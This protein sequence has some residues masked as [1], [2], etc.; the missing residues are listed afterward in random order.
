MSNELLSTQLSIAE[1]DQ[2]AFAFL[3][4]QY[5]KQLKKFAKALVRS[6]EISEEIVED[7]FVK[8]WCNR[9]T[10]PQIENLIVYMYVAV[11]NTS[12]NTLSK[13][14]HELIS[15][16]FDFLDIDVNDQSFNPY[17]LLITSEMMDR[18]QGAINS[19]PP[20]CKMIFKLVREDGLRYKEIAEILNISVNT[21]DV[22]M[23]IAIK[24]ICSALDV[25]KTHKKG[26]RNKVSGEY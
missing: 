19:L 3:Y 2:K 24:R 15:A 20:R 17:E 25:Q 21:I 7:V 26:V 14:S 1:G 12:L 22:Q 4:K 13:K 8:L 6:N 5:N 9:S 10:L 23:S 11:K 16:P 18:M